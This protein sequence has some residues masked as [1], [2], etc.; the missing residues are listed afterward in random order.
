MRYYD[1][2]KHISSNSLDVVIAG[3]S[4]A[5]RREYLSK[6]ADILVMINGGRGTLD[7]ALHGLVAGKRL[8]VASNTGGKSELMPVIKERGISNVVYEAR[9]L[10]FSN[11][12]ITQKERDNII[13]ADNIRDIVRYL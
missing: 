3:D 5:D 11:D 12:N 4:M 10:G 13:C 1:L 2:A 7:E 6:I 9:I 8:I